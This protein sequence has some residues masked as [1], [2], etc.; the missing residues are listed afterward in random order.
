MWLWS[1]L[2]KSPWPW[3]LPKS[4]LLSGPH[5]MGPYS[6]KSH[7]LSLY[8]PHKTLTQFFFFTS[9]A[10]AIGPSVNPLQNRETQHVNI[11]FA[12]YVST[13]WTAKYERKSSLVS[14]QVLPHSQLIFPLKTWVF[15]IY[16]NFQRQKSL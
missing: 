1:L 7:N 2:C 12:M 9:V 5:C 16:L 4:S 10:C 6:E 13:F 8:L 3:A 15:G 14:L 11:V